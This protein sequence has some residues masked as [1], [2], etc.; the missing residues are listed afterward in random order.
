MTSPTYFTKDTEFASSW[1]ESAPCSGWD[2]DEFSPREDERI[3][4][5]YK[6]MERDGNPCPVDCPVM[7][8]CAKGALKERSIGVIRAGIYI[9]DSHPYTAESR[10]YLEKVVDVLESREN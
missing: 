6:R 3:T 5:F 10:K 4:D 2:L 9:P 8:E 7:L 1:H